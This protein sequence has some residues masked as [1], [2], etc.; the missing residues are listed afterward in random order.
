MFQ[1][2]NFYRQ[3]IFS[4]TKKHLQLAVIKFENKATRHLLYGRFNYRRLAYSHLFGATSFSIMTLS[5]KSLFVTV[6]VNDSQHNNTD[7]MLI[8]CVEL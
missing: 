5:I 6:S 2:R 4:R 8:F 7:N 1:A 3:K